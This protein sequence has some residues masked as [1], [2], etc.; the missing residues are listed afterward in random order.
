MS[1]WAHL[2]EVWHKRFSIHP[3]WKAKAHSIC[4]YY[5]YHV[6]S[7]RLSLT[8]R[9]SQPE[10]GLLLVA[11][12]LPSCSVI[13]F[14]KGEKNIKQTQ[15]VPRRSPAYRNLL[16]TGGGGSSRRGWQSERGWGA[17]GEAFPQGSNILTCDLTSDG[18]GGV[19]SRGQVSPSKGLVAGETPSTPIQ[20][21]HFQRQQKNERVQNLFA[22][23]Q[24]ASFTSFCGRLLGFTVW[25]QGCRY[26]C[27]LAL[28][29]I[30]PETWLASSGQQP[31][32]TSYCSHSRRSRFQLTALAH[33]CEVVRETCKHKRQRERVRGWSACLG[34]SSIERITWP[35]K[36][37]LVEQVAFLPFCWEGEG[38]VSVHWWEM[39]G[40]EGS[41]A[42]R[43]KHIHTKEVNEWKSRDLF[44][45]G[46]SCIGVKW[47]LPRRTAKQTGL[48]GKNVF[49]WVWSRERALVSYCLFRLTL[50]GLSFLC[51]CCADVPLSFIM[52]KNCFR[53]CHFGMVQNALENQ[54][55]LCCGPFVGGLLIL[56]P[57]KLR[58]KWTFL[59][60]VCFCRTGWLPRWSWFPTTI[61]TTLG[62]YHCVWW[63]IV[64]PTMNWELPTYNSFSTS[65]KVFLA[66][67]TNRSLILFSFQLGRLLSTHFILPPKPLCRQKCDQFKP[68]EIMWM[69][70]FWNLWG[71]LMGIRGCQCKIL[72]VLCWY[73]DNG[74]EKNV[75]VQGDIGGGMS[76]WN[77]MRWFVFKRA[78]F[79]FCSRKAIKYTVFRVCL[80]GATIKSL[81]VISDLGDA[82]RFC[83]CKAALS[84]VVTCTA[85]L[86]IAKRFHLEIRWCWYETLSSF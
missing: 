18:G 23:R 16:S 61:H 30:L 62:G 38:G 21:R 47:L 64:I 68:L 41:K 57:A 9:L 83:S 31:H 86:F 80:S 6:I 3:G 1:R 53:H 71:K 8:C 7:G 45:L 13:N 72:L 54:C 44:R 5:V 60:R 79:L 43:F 73:R 32:H 76:P 52:S 82:S 66:K 25:V 22:V 24:Q 59:G 48:W 58:K 37:E 77:A 35:A 11:E 69:S 63:S 50:R 46:S 51:N 10:S 12:T 28:Q 74:T 26:Q 78:R 29:S 85:V 4:I 14:V 42:K 65:A 67:E 40:K 75:F 2:S 56:L 70:K 27:V 36:P 34:H 15:A 55:D 17:E 81:N 84:V 39:D 19:T 20:L 49:S 33:S